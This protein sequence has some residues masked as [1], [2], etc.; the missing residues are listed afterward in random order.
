MIV[1]AHH[2]LWNY[3]PAEYIWIGE[4]MQAIAR[5]FSVPDFKAASQGMGVAGSVVVQARQTLDETRWLLSLASDDDFLLGVV[6]WLPLGDPNLPHVLEGF[7]EQPKLKGIRHIVHDEPNDEYL[8]G[9]DFN[10]GIAAVLQRGYVYDIL[11][12]ERHLPHAITFADRHPSGRLVLD[13]IAKP[14]IAEGVFEPWR[15]NLLELARREHV[16]CKLSGVATEAKWDN[17]NLETIRPYLDTVL[18]AF[19]PERMMFGS[20]WPVC[21]LACDYAAWF[22]TVVEWA[23]PLA[24]A[25]RARL[26][27]GTAIETYGLQQVVA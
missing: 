26:F 3:V 15:Q 9:E 14:K 5:D 7:S 16:T 27:G 4:S 20:D 25:E 22:Q 17:W 12:F 1:D 18:E 21:L 10:R 23:E 8:L 11:I 2:H 6:G 19:G 13:H 24:E